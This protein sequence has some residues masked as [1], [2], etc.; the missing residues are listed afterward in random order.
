MLREDRQRISF[1]ASSMRA[2]SVRLN[3]QIAQALCDGMRITGLA[4]ASELSRWTI[5]TIGLSSEDLLPSG[6]P[7]GQHLAVISQLTSE[8]A[9]LEESKA[10]LE[11][12]RLTLMAAARRL[13]VMDDY[14]LAALS[15]LQRDTVRKMTGCRRPE[16]GVL[17]A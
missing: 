6:L 14:E 5:R 4:E 10:I 16:S 8:L 7:A 3:Q 12:S 1:N 17:P 9:E 2:L 11:E 15:G 13:G